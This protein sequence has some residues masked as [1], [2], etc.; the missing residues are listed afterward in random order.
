MT[1]TEEQLALMDWLRGKGGIGV[2]YCGEDDLSD[3][4]P[5]YCYEERQEYHN[6]FEVGL[7]LQLQNKGG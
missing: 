7:I 5:E 4:L 3:H 2:G 6:Y 1:T